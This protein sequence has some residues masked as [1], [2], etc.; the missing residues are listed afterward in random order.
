MPWASHDIVSDRFF[1]IFITK[2]IEYNDTVDSRRLQRCADGHH[3]SLAHALARDKPIREKGRF[4]YTGTPV[5]DADWLCGRT[6][7]F[8][9]VENVRIGDIRSA[10]DRRQ[11]TD[12]APVTESLVLYMLLR[13]YD[14]CAAGYTGYI[15]SWTFCDTVLENLCAPEQW[16]RCGILP[17]YR[18]MEGAALVD[19]RVG[20]TFDVE[21]CVPWD[22][23]EAVVDINAADVVMLGS[24]PDK[25]GLVGRR[26]DAAPS[27]ILQGRDSRSIRFLVPDVR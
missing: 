12:A 13:L 19:D 27:R 5:T 3:R 21:L 26:K 22:A 2:Q 25:V 18:T 11:S 1:F 17:V 8:V 9:P 4:G 7:L 16:L 10:V 6:V 15:E 23:P 24:V 20:V 14:Y